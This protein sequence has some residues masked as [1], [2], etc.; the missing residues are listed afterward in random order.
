MI[1]STVTV[2]PSRGKL[3]CGTEVVSWPRSVTPASST[4][5]RTV[6]ALVRTVRGRPSAMT[7]TARSVRT[8]SVSP[9]RP[10]RWERAADRYAPSARTPHSLSAPPTVRAV[11]H[12][13]C[14]CPSSVS[15]TGRP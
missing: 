2:C 5:S 1:R 4:A 7:V 14:R 13:A 12:A 8:S 10:M 11:V 9:V 3:S 6:A 15:R